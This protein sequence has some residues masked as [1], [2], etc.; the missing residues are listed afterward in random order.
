MK[1]SQ[2]E[3]GE[4]DGIPT[5]QNVYGEVENLPE[6]QEGTY[7]LVNAMVLTASTRMDLL[8]PDTGPTAIRDEKG[9]VKEVVRFVTK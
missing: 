5:V 2:V 9:Q 4:V 1:V 8:A 3:L 6:P 7:F